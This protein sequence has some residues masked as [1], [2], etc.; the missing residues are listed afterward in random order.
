MVFVVV[1]VVV[2]VIVIHVVVPA[3]CWGFVVVKLSIIDAP[4][5]LF[6]F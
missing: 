2:V 4:L 3:V 5:T 6:Q 1:V